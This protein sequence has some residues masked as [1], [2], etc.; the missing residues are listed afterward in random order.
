MEQRSPSN[1]WAASKLALGSALGLEPTLFLFIDEL[2]FPLSTRDGWTQDGGGLTVVPSV[3]WKPGD[4][5][6]VK[7]AARQVLSAQTKAQD[8]YVKGRT[9]RRLCAS[10]AS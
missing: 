5:K 10:A 2:F 7:H 4:L 6:L 3:L 9:R 8:V 1:I